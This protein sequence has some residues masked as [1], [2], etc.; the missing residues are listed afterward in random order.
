MVSMRSQK[1]SLTLV[2]RSAFTMIELIYAIVVIGVTVLTVPL[3]I[4][5]NNQGLEESVHQE[6]V[7]LVSSVLSITTTLVWDN[8]SVVSTPGADNYVLAKMLDIQDGSNYDRLDINSTLRIG[9]L[10]QDM[11]RQFFDYNGSY[12]TPAQTG[13]VTL[14]ATIDASA[15]S[16]LGFKE[17]Y[18][19]RATRSYVDDTYGADLSTAVVGGQTNLKMTTLEIYGEN[20]DLISKLRAFTANIGEVDFARRDF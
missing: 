20:G 9:G 1:A 19:V 11:H 5:T 3:M 13:T 18:N 10:N 4:Q 8:R 17:I 16:Q 15:A 7:F 14:D 12:I 6:A 2:C